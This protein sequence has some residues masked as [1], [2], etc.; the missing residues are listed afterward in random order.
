MPDP[1]LLR[2]CSGGE[3]EWGEGSC[4]GFR[5]HSCLSLGISKLRAWA[6]LLEGEEVMTV[7]HAASGGALIVSLASEWARR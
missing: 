1:E 3:Q 2:A 4:K 7:V 6:I 5:R